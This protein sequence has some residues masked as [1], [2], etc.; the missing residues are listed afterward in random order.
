[1]SKRPV[2][3]RPRI[4]LPK[5]V[6]DYRA[7]I[8]AKRTEISNFLFGFDPGPALQRSEDGDVLL[9]GEL[10]P[11]WGIDAWAWVPEFKA[12]EDEEITVRV[13]SPGGYVEDGILI[14]NAIADHAADVTVIV[15][16][17]AASAASFLSMAA[18]KIIMNRGA[19]MM[20][21][22]A[23]GMAFGGAEDL[24]DYA[25]LMDLENE[26]IAEIYAARSGVKDAAHWLVEMDRDHYYTAPQAVEAGLADERIELKKKPTALATGGVVD[27]PTFVGDRGPELIDLSAALDSKNVIDENP[28]AEDAAALEAAAELARQRAQAM[29]AVARAR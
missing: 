26:N 20:I 2:A 22:K 7:A 24:R 19:K 4:D 16:A 6:L 12:I 17:T 8:S 25:D 15:D 5:N 14:Y 3:E 27:T 13:D 21:H 29:A 23:H 28:P 9:Y 1:M 18:D 10:H 11:Y